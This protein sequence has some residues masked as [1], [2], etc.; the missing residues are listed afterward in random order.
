[1]DDISPP[2]DL[3]LSARNAQLPTPGSKI[4][5]LLSPPAL[6]S[7]TTLHLQDRPLSTAPWQPVGPLWPSRSP[8][9]IYDI[10]PAITPTVYVIPS[11]LP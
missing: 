6:P 7:I 4:Q 9:S 2:L 3:F 11:R 5:F 1:M 10:A 8:L